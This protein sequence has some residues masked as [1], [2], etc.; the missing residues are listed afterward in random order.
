MSML[1]KNYL[2]TKVYIWLSF[3]IISLLF[4]LFPQVDI[5]TSNLFFDGS[6]FLKR[7]PVE[8]LF[9]YSVRPIIILVSI[10]VIAVFIFNLIK[11]QNILGINRRVF[12]YIFLTLSLAPGL[13]VNAGLKVNWDRARPIEI[14]EFH[15]TKE[16]TPAFIISDQDG[17]SFSSGHVAAAFSLYGLA[18]LAKRRRNLWINLSLGYGF[19]MCVARMAAG[20]H[21]LSDTIT[22]FFIVYITSNLLY[23]F[24][25]EK[26]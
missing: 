13:I 25:I 11:K 1:N 12:I 18:L 19:G 15:G 20:G 23:Y 9:Y 5:L 17:Q 21:F 3:F 14:K 16:F 6:W 22:S 2:N 4:V 24:I 7:S 10:T 26:K 8:S